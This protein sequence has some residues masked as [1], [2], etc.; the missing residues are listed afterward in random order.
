MQGSE[1]DGR[2]TPLNNPHIAGRFYVSRHRGAGDLS[3][4]GHD[5]VK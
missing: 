5:E 3:K 4:D 1:R 2:R